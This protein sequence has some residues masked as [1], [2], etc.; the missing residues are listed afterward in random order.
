[1]KV[2]GFRRFGVFL[3]S[4]FCLFLG[5]GCQKNASSSEETTKPPQSYSP[6]KTSVLVPDAP[7]TVTTGGDPLI[8]DF[9]NA[10][11]GYFMGKL[12]QPDTKVNIQ[13]TGPDDVCYKYFLTENDIWTAFPITAGDGPYLVL[14][15]QE[16]S[17]GQY[18]SLFSYPLDVSL[19]NEFY[20]F[21]YPN[22]YVDFTAGSKAISLA[23][24][25]TADSAEDLDALD[26][27]YQYVT[28]HITYDEEKA[29]TVGTGYLPDI[30]ETLRTGKGI[31]FDYAAL[32]AA[33]LR[34][35]SIPARLDIG[36]SGDIR[37]AWVDVYIESI[38]WVKRAVEFNGN[39]WK[40]IDPTF[41]AAAGNEDNEAIDEYIGD[42][43]NYTVQY[44]R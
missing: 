5:S 41:A 26:D 36:Y 16:I 28:T 21:L 10:D 22:Q 14:A 19:D 24:S 34:S 1:M 43:S 38:G 8:L 12:T 33:M 37:H 11:H 39:E 18:S 23:A 30:D 2:T 35:L 15:Y 31:C 32:T 42:S 25:L 3:L 13:I 40:M 9:S 27:I 17:D 7:G 4:L 29:A 20:P 44:I 6:G